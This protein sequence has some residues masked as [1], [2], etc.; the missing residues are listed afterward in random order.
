MDDL[1]YFPSDKIQ[2]PYTEIKRFIDFVKQLSEL[3]EDIRFDDNYWK[4]EVSFVK[5]GVPIKNQS[6]ENLLHHSILE[7]AKAYVKYQRI[8]SKLKT[9][10]TIRAIRA[11]EQLCLVRYGEVDLTKLII[12]DFDLAAEEVKKNFKASSAYNVGRHLK[13]LL[14]FLRQLKIVDLPDWKNPI[15]KNADKSIVLDKKSEEY[16]ASKL[17]DENAIFALADIF[18]RKISDLS[19]RDIFVTSAANLLLAAPERASELFFLK[20]NCV[21]EEEIQTFSKSSLG[22]VA[23]SSIIEKTLGIRWYAQKNYGYDIKYI[24]SVMI[25]T[26]KRA[27]ERLIKMSEKPRY[28]AYL[29]E[30]SD[31]FPRHELCPKVPDDQLLK[32]SE[33]LLAMGF[34]VSLY[35]DARKENDSGIKFLKTRE[36]PISDY[37]VCLNDLNILLRNRLPKDFPYVPFQTGNGVKVKWSEALFA[38]FVHQFNKSKSTIFSELWMPNIGTLNEDL[39]PTR[40]KLR[41]KNELSNTQS[42]FQRWG[43]GDHS[44][45]T[46]QFR[47]L[48]NTIANTNGMDSLLLAKWSGRADIKQNRVYDHT[49]VEDRNY[50]L[51]EMQKNE[52]GTV[53]ADS[54]FTFQIATPRTLQELNTRTTLSMHTTEYGLCT[55]SYIDEPC[56]KYRNCLNCTEHVCI[57]GDKEKTKRLQDRLKKEKILWQKDKHA[58]EKNVTGAKMWLETRELTIQRCEQLVALLNDPNIPDGVPLSL[59]PSEEVTHLELAYQKAGQK[60]LPIIENKRRN[61]LDDIH[62]LPSSDSTGT[63][64]L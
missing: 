5:M 40:K 64:I 32:R 19:D 16:R 50:S 10:D 44:I 2:S 15:K 31:K 45:T 51:I 26:V 23:D 7:F 24:P 17:P 30:K 9:A 57:K 60:R 21:Y 14:D 39:S 48:L 54:T 62:L 52:V 58:V 49:T 56:L 47:H 11:I 25:P 12:A 34:D 33:V 36:I 8:N 59:P 13:I 6:P 3:N 22:L 61:N 4:F 27:I 55:H 46:H 43:Y 41:G 35:N 29:L 28:L 1:I 20:Y 63:W 38:C 37:S 53:N 42:I 18:S